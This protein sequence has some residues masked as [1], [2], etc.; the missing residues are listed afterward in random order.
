[1]GKGKDAEA[2][3]IVH[4]VARRNGKTSNLTL[5]DLQACEALAA[6]GTSTHAA[7]TATAAVKRKL[8][9]L[10]ASHVKALFS[11]RKMA[12]ST[13]LI[14]MIWAFIGYYIPPPPMPF[15][16][17]SVSLSINLWY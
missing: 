14:T 15:P 2:V 12:F 10:D 3:R 9:K 6:P 17:P 5:E 4:E 7:T 13:S 8:E 16:H 11:T 1:M